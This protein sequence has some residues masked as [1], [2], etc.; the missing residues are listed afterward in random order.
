MPKVE[1]HSV[2]AVVKGHQRS[3]KVFGERFMN[4]IRSDC[5]DAIANNFLGVGV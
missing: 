3:N 5:K 4:A 1:T 2:L